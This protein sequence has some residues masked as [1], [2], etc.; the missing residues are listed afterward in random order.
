MKGF[1]DEDDGIMGGFIFKIVWKVLLRIN[2]YV[3]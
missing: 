3:I 1:S 2:G